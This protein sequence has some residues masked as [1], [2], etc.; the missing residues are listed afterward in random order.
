[1]AD[2]IK[3]LKL[4]STSSGGGQNDFSPT[5]TNPNE[6]YI[7]ILG[8]SFTANLLRT[9]DLD[10]SGNIQFKDATETSPITVRQ[11]RTA[12][13]NIFDNSTN[14]FTS[15]NV[16]AAIEEVS[17]GGFSWRI[18]QPMQRVRPMRH[19]AIPSCMKPSLKNTNS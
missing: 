4:E 16:Q 2:I 19:L 8:V 5:E 9:I 17:A 1:M 3:P 7:G 18:I 14:G 11:L 12:A 13:S 6:D 15:S 10:G